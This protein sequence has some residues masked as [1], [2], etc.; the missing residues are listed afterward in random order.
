MRLFRKMDEMELSINFKA[1]RL[2]WLFGIIFLLV[3]VW[4]DWI[5]GRTFNSLGVILLVSQLIVYWAGQAFFKWQL[6]KDEE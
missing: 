2:A 6:G 5:I 3:W 1:L 4:M